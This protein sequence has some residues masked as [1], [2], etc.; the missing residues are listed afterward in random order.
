MRAELPVVSFL[1][2]ALLLIILPG[3]IKSNTVPAV[4]IIAWLFFSNLIHGVNSIIWSGNTDEHA[5]VWCDIATVVLHGAMAALPGSFLCISRRLEM[6]TSFREAGKKHSKT[7]N[8]VF[9]VTMCLL[10]P[11]VYM[12]LHTIVQ[13][14][15]FSIVKDLG[16]QTAVYNSLPALILVWL[17]PLCISTISVVYCLVSAVI[18][19]SK[20]HYNERPY[21]PLAPEMTLSLFIRRIIFAVSGMLYVAV[22][23]V[24]ILSTATSSGLSTWTSVSKARSGISTVEILSTPS[25][26]S[27]ESELTWWFVPVWSLLLCVLSAFGEETQRGYRSM[28]KWLS[29]RFRGEVL[30]T[31]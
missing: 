24:I 30:P 20:S 14:H 28:F 5:L 18:N 6:I 16:C 12:A 21:F 7:Y 3:Q 22:V 31:Q 27:V 1:S 13:D 8:R 17:P 10:L 4:S 29:Q 9:E 25:Q 19:V 11:V 2:L 23:Y 15:R 26:I